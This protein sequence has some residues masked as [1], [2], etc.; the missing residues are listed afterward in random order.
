LSLYQVALT[1]HILGAVIG[2][3]PAFVLPIVSRQFRTPGSDTRPFM[4]VMKRIG[5][6]PS[7]GLPLQILSGFMMGGMNPRFWESYWLRIAF[8]LVVALLVL[9]AAVMAPLGKK[10]GLLLSELDQE[11]GRT[12]FAALARRLNIWHIVQ[13]S[14]VA[15]ILLLMITKPF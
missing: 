15:V 6:L 14:V 1:I 9:G 10:M 12:R 5:I 4:G 11:V 3:G 2:M 8:L 7:I 13:A